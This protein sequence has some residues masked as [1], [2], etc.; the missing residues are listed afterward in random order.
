M[1]NHK[2]F[3]KILTVEH[4]FK[5]RKAAGS[6]ISHQEKGNKHF[7]FTFKGFKK[8]FNKHANY[9]QTVICTLMKY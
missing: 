7:N 8:Y 4:V 3:N 5:I 6:V 9:K 1:Y 2:I